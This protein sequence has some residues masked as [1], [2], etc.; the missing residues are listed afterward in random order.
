[1][2]ALKPWVMNA[3][4]ESVN[5]ILSQP[6]SLFA[7]SPMT[8]W[9]TVSASEQNVLLVS[10][11]PIRFFASHR[12]NNRTECNQPKPKR[13][14]FHSFN[15]STVRRQIQFKWSHIESS[16]DI[17]HSWRTTGLFRITLSSTS[18]SSLLSRSSLHLFEHRKVILFRA[19]SRFVLT[20]FLSFLGAYRH[21]A[22]TRTLASI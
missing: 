10:Q 20:V 22:H 12:V 2:C 7:S 13:T 3:S 1:M 6:I 15:D 4:F 14:I 19:I 11:F 8:F 5:L 21:S 9:T 18:M 16:R 17:L